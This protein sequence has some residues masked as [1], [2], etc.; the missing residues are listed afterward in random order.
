MAKAKYGPA[1]QRERAKWKQVVD[2]GEANCCLC[3]KWIAPGS[4]WDL[5]HLPGTGLYRGAACRG[6]NRSDGA[7]RGNRARVKRRWVL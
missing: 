4:L 5:D 1:H 3:G 7:A 2:A 6:C